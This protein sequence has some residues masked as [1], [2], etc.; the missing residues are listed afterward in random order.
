MKIG[1]CADM[2]LPHISGVTNHIRLSKKYFEDQGHE[3]FLFTFGDLDYEDTEPR[4]HRTPALP[5]R[6][7]GW[8]FGLVHSLESRKLLKQMD[9]LH[10]HH[11]FQSG[12]QAVLLAERNK[13]PL[14]FTNHTRYDLYSDLYAEVIP[15][16]PRYGTIKS[17]L[18]AFYGDCDLVI[19]PSA[20]INEWMAD[21]LEFDGA[22]TMPNG[23][24]THAFGNPK[25]EITRADVGLREDDFVFLYMGRVT[26][27]KNIAYVFDEF[28]E[29]ARKVPNAKLLVVGGGALLE[30]EQERVAAHELGNHII[31]VGAQPYELLPDYAALADCFTTGSVSEVHPLVVLEALAAGLPAIG[32]ESPGISDTV[33]AGVSG[34]LAAAPEPTLLATEMLKVAT[35][36]ALRTQ[37]SDGARVRAQDYSL[38]NTA[39][40]VLA[41]YEE[42]V[43]RGR[44]PS[45]SDI[46]LENIREYFSYP[47]GSH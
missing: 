9:I 2:Y 39:G 25:R 35:D 47:G 23:I 46:L 27:E 40:R 18:K 45:R 33:Q 24:N 6:D 44:R 28:L 3:V 14:V 5:F 12:L 1:I 10:V 34:L 30:S 7:T 31:F 4:V 16:R 21:F 11:P 13:I 8:N 29:L 41:Y 20:S 26:A 15:Q 19:A 43:E 42:L 22:V 36:P 32:V 38:D 17:Y 37:L